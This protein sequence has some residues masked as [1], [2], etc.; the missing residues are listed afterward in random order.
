[1]L[2]VS[3]RQGLLVTGQNLPDIA[4]AMVRLTGDNN[5]NYELLISLF[6]KRLRNTR[7]LEIPEWVKPTLEY[8]EPTKAKGI[9][10]DYVKLLLVTYYREHDRKTPKKE[11]CNTWAANQNQDIFTGRY[12]S[13]RAYQSENRD[14]QEKGKKRRLIK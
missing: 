12:S 11:W 5:I 4:N 7:T 14:G 6:H 2:A 13:E 1:V 9:P 10:D 8:L 3:Q